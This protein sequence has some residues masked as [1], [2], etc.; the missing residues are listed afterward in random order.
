[1]F[2]VFM[3]AIDFARLMDALDNIHAFQKIDKQKLDTS[4]RTLDLQ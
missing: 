2:F 4:K 1:M 3:F